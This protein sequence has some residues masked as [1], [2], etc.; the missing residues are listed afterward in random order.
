MGP[1]TVV[2]LCLSPT[3]AAA[4]AHAMQAFASPLPHSPHSLDGSPSALL[5]DVPGEDVVLNLPPSRYPIEDPNLIT[6]RSP[7]STVSSSPAFFPPSSTSSH[8]DRTERRSTDVSPQP[9]VRSPSSLNSPP[10]IAAAHKEALERR[11][12]KNTQLS[13]ATRNKGIDTLRLN[14]HSLAR[15]PSSPNVPNPSTARGASD[16]SADVELSVKGRTKG[17]THKVPSSGGGG[18][19]GEG[20]TLDFGLDLD[21]NLGYADEH[22]EESSEGNERSKK[23]A[24]NPLED[25][26][27]ENEKHSK[28][29]SHFSAHLHLFSYVL[30]LA[31]LRQNTSAFYRNWL[32]VVTYGCT[33]ICFINLFLHTKGYRNPLFDVTLVLL[34][35]LVCVSHEYWLGYCKSKEWKTMMGIV[36]KVASQHFARHIRL[37]GWFGLVMVSG[38][39]VTIVLGWEIPIFSQMALQV[40]GKS[41]DP[42]GH[43]DNFVFLT[44]HGIFMIVIIAPWAAVCMCSVCL[45]KLVV[46]AHQSDIEHH[47]SH[48]KF[49]IVQSLEQLAAEQALSDAAGMSISRKTVTSI[50]ESGRFTYVKRDVIADCFRHIV[51]HHQAVRGRLRAT[52]KYFDFL[53]IGYIVISTLL[54]FSAAMDFNHYASGFPFDSDTWQDSVAYQLFPHLV[55]DIFYMGLGLLGVYGCF[56]VTSDLSSSFDRFV[57]RINDLPIAF[58]HSSFSLVTIPPATLAGL[59]NYYKT[60]HTAYTVLDTPVTFTLFAMYSLA[61]AAILFFNLWL[62]NGGV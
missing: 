11:D 12:R 53:Y 4:A 30:L 41:I 61:C 19:N 52:C 8:P 20:V 10:S 27:K 37:L 59:V 60:S 58:P 47:F 50:G 49:T 57:R 42:D 25:E 55:Q 36:T 39:T 24:V 13:T 54:V 31:G 17:L 14:S 9:P 48:L 33:A 62:V 40:Q 23:G 46:L 21:G 1:S 56:Y 22:A 7:S 3:S 15:H 43:Q 29:F 35:I 26:A 51:K 38:A 16:S 5:A 18:G 44:L 32:R 28:V 6:P 34:H 45:F 2:P